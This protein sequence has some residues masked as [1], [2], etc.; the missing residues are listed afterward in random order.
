MFR[1]SL[2]LWKK[3]KKPCVV[4]FQYYITIYIL[5]KNYAFYQKKKTMLLWSI[6]LKNKFI[7]VETII[8]AAGIA[9]LV[10]ACGC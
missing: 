10:R 7:F 3:E 4:D 9:Q 6:V 5:R 1:W 2:A 8:S